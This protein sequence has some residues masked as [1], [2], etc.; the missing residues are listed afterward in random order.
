MVDYSF[1][2]QYDPAQTLALIAAFSIIPENQDKI[3][4][5]E[6]AARIAGGNCRGGSEPTLS[7]IHELISQTGR[8]MLGRSLKLGGGLAGVFSSQSAFLRGVEGSND[9]ATEAAWKRFSAHDSV[10]KEKIGFT[11]ANAIFFS[12]TLVNM[13]SARTIDTPPPRRTQISQEQFYDYSF[14]VE[15]DPDLAKTWGKAIQFGLK[16]LEECVPAAV[17]DRVAAF[18]G[19]VSTPIENCPQSPNPFEESPL[20]ERPVFKVGDNHLATFQSYLFRGMS[21]R[22]HKTLISDSRYWGYYGDRK[23]KVLEEWTS[24]ALRRAFPSATILRNIMYKGEKGSGEAD[25]V[26]D[27]A[28]NLLF[29]ECTTKW[30]QSD[31]K[32]GDLTA[33]KFDLAHSVS[34]CYEQAIRAKEAYLAGHLTLPI[35]Q[36]PVKITL[37]VVT[38]VLFPNLLLEMTVE[39]GAKSPTHGRFLKDLVAERDY[40]WIVSVFDIEALTAMVDERR[41]MEFVV[42][43]TEISK[44]GNMLAQDEPDYLRF[45]L[46]PEFQLYKKSLEKTN[47]ILNYSGSP[48]LPAKKSRLFLGIL[49]AIGSEMS[50]IIEMK[51]LAGREGRAAALDTL[52]SVYCNWEEAMDHVVTNIGEF[53]KT[54]KKHKAAGNPCKAIAWEGFWEFVQDPR[55]R[56]SKMDKIREISESLGLRALIALSYDVGIEAL[57]ELQHAEG[58]EDVRRFVERKKFLDDT[59]ASSDKKS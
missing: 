17:R 11:V 22:L 43:R 4:F 37:V 24:E 39:T 51:G 10:L 9:Q 55:D 47:S 54:L 30:I 7:A 34:K 6:L 25:I 18:L 36:L 44:L 42:E 31:S 56:Q 26:L 14:F 33:V 16:D 46:K 59:S 2:R 35:K 48:E 12:R 13:V 29:V 19:L 23:G 50:L 27:F 21:L 28:G 8:S 5:I 40:P 38:D 53:E 58:E 1:L 3:A 49:E 52:Y 32:K 45:F 20:L 57:L 41:L 15:P